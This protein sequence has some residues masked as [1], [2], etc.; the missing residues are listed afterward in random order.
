MPVLLNNKLSD[1]DELTHQVKKHCINPIRDDGVLVILLKVRKF[2]ESF[3]FEIRVNDF[4]EFLDFRKNGKP[5]INVFSRY[6]F[7]ILHQIFQIMKNINK[8]CRKYTPGNTGKFEKNSGNFPARKFPLSILVE[9]VWL[10]KTFCQILPKNLA[11][12]LW[13]HFLL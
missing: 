5:G 11:W 7:K 12:N 9:R 1:K 6:I 8:N 3:A 13:A 10:I 2:F 4:P